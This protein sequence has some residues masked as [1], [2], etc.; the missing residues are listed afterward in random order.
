M[1]Q[2]PLHDVANLDLLSMVPTLSQNVIEV[3]CMSGALAR[4]YK[5]INPTARY[6][7]IDINEQYANLAKTYCDETFCLNIETV[8][9]G[10]YADLSFVDCWIF[11]DVLEHL[12]DPWRILQEIK[13][14]IPSNGAVVACIPNLQHWSLV[15]KIVSGD[16][17]YENSG[18]LDRTHLRW[19]T[20]QTIVDLFDGAGFQIYDMRSRSIPHQH[21]E[22]EHRI[23]E[24]LIETGRQYG[25]EPD[26]VRQDLK[27]FQY[28]LA[29]RPKPNW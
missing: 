6:I 15:A 23:T 12:V 20:R 27:A 5:K 8:Q 14:V 22:L 4:E 21:L 25:A 10:F 7:G 1:R 24:A 16:F 29:A 2:T 19:F 13:A 17:R 18:L 3:G 26:T 9:A 11:G 28:V